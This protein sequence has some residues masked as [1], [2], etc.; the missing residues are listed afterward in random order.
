LHASLAG[1]PTPRSVRV[2]SLAE[3]ARLDAT[4]DFANHEPA[5]QRQR[6][7]CA[8]IVRVGAPRARL[9]RARD[10]KPP[11]PTMII[12]TVYGRRA[13]RGRRDQALRTGEAG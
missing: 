12:V 10:S 11:S 1:P 3:L 13:V 7:D 8:Q 9:D 4:E 6:P 2:A 5:R